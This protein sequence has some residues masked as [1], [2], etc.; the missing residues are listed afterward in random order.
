MPRK[1]W[2]DM[3]REE[4]R[5]ANLKA[6]VKAGDLRRTL[7]SLDWGRVM[8]DAIAHRPTSFG[9]R[10]GQ[11]PVEWRGFSEWGNASWEVVASVV[12]ALEKAGAIEDAAKELIRK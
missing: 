11:D 9:L 12:K 1:K 3:T 8:L 2:D 4:K 5:E 7:Y 10:D 6:A